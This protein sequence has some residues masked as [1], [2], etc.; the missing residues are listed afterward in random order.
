[1]NLPDPFDKVLNYRPTVN[2]CD[3]RQTPALAVGLPVTVV[4]TNENYP[5]LTQNHCVIITTIAGHFECIRSGRFDSRTSARLLVICGAKPTIYPELHPFV[6][7]P[8]LLLSP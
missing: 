3:C 8:C 1:M 5:S 4:G 7:L 2:L 6:P